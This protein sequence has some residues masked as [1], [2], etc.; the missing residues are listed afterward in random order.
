MKKRSVLLLLV[1]ILLLTACTPAV[2]EQSTTTPTTQTTTETAVPPTETTL[3]AVLKNTDRYPLDTDAVLTAVTGRESADRTD[4]WQLF[5]RVTGVDIQWQYVEKDQTLQMLQSSDEMPDI[6][7]QAAGLSVDEIN[8]CGNAGK[9]INYMD[10]LDQMPNLSARYA[11]DPLL[12]SAVEDI[13]G[14][15]YTLPHIIKT[16][17]TV[18]N[19]FYIRTDHTSA[20]GWD[21]MP[22]TVEEF[23]LLCE[24]LQNTYANVDGYV[25]MVCNGAASITYDGAYA[26]FFFPAFGKLV[27]P[28]ITTN[29]EKDTI[30]AGFATEQFKQYL[31]F[32]HTL[33]EEE[34]MDSACFTAVSAD[35]KQKMYDGTTSMNPFATYLTSANFASGEMDFQVMPALSS[36]YQSQARWVRPNYR[37]AGTYMIS[38]N[39][40]DLGAALA[41][42]DALMADESDPLNEEG[43]VWGVS[44]YVGEVGK[45]VTVNK[46]EGYFVIHGD[47]AYDTPTYS[48]GW[49]ATW[50]SGTGPYVVWPYYNCYALGTKVKTMGQRY[51]LDPDGVDVFYA[52]SWLRMTSEEQAIYN[53]LWPEIESYIAQRNEAFITGQADLDTQWKAYLEELNALGLQQVI[54]IYQAA[55]DRYWE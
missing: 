44:M 28:G 5:E 11:E 20:A 54:D 38:S 10:Y 12:F 22:A 27:Q 9:L 41:F 43:T 4:N 45:N 19:L 23:L 49:L 16:L 47:P 18:S 50:G 51:I 34:Y 36:K 17:G 33:Y 48:E 37:L 2:R 8:A 52:T 31:Q 21:A 26:R 29:A 55:L 30:I 53:D 25:P 6:F 7:F 13:D 3:P 35:S 40:S 32:M 15:V 39:C 24:D 42:M 14:N 1:L 46:E